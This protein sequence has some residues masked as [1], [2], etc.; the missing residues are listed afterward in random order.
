MVLY[1]IPT[2]GEANHM[3]GWEHSIGRHGWVHVG[4][5]AKKPIYY[6]GFGPLP[7]IFQCNV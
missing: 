2:C 3:F 5:G 7:W 1:P 4:A 6:G